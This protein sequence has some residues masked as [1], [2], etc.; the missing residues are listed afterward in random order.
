MDR[1]GT[2]PSKVRKVKEGEGQSNFNLAEFD[3][4]VLKVSVFDLGTGSFLSMD[5]SLFQ[6][7]WMVTVA[8]L[9]LEFLKSWFCSLLRSA[10]G[11][12]AAK[13]ICSSLWDQFALWSLEYCEEAWCYL[14]GVEG[15]KTTRDE[16][17]KKSHW[18]L[19][20]VLGP[21]YLRPSWQ[22][23]SETAS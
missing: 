7:L 22:G 3:R 9:L 15:E 16:K 21:S 2:R 17:E 14:W 23:E 13:C 12:L 20:S 1:L 5:S 8:P 18:D 4:P 6:G 10:G 19:I 11:H